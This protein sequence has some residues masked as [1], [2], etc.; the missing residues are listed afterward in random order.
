MSY[1]AEACRHFRHAYRVRVYLNLPSVEIRIR[2]SNSSC[3]PVEHILTVQPNANSS[4]GL[5]F[6]PVSSTIVCLNISIHSTAQ[7]IQRP[8]QPRTRGIVYYTSTRPAQ[9][10][11]PKSSSHHTSTYNYTSCT[12][13]ALVSSSTRLSHPPTSASRSS[14]ATISL[15]SP[16]RSSAVPTWE[17]VHEPWASPLIV[18]SCVWNFARDGLEG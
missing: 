16:I 11:N 5:Y 3:R 12:L 4:D 10:S 7:F 15:P 13:N 18:S 8:Q 6:E 1:E 2:D 9:A 14:S 17:S